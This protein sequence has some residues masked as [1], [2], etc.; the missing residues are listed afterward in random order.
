MNEDFQPQG[1]WKTVSATDETR[2]N[3]IEELKREVKEL[4]HLIDL[5]ERGEGF[6]Q[7]EGA[8]AAAPHE[9]VIMTY[10][11]RIVAKKDAITRLEMLN[12]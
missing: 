10:K 4:E 6:T 12:K 1:S 2:T 11:E 7:E 9:S 5:H 3:T 8:I